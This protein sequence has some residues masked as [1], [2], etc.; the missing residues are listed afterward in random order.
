MK[1]RLLALPLLFLAIT[2]KAEIIDR[3]LV[4]YDTETGL[5]WLDATETRDMNYREVVAEMGVGGRLFGWRHATT[6]ELDQLLYHFG[7][8]P[9]TANCEHGVA[10]CTWGGV[11]DEE[12]L[13]DII[14]ML[15][16]TLRAYFEIS[17]PGRYTYPDGV[18]TSGGIVVHGA[19]PRL[20]D[21]NSSEPSQIAKSL[22]QDGEITSDGIIPGDHADAVETISYFVDSDYR[23]GSTG[24]RLVKCEWVTLTS[25]P[26][27]CVPGLRLVPVLYPIAEGVV[28]W[29][30]GIELPMV[31]IRQEHE[32]K[33]DESIYNDETEFDTGPSLPDAVY[34]WEFESAKGKWSSK[35]FTSKEQAFKFLDEQGFKYQL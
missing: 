16:D 28:Y 18:G 17:E 13:E 26:Y 1:L 33:I 32:Y 2:V 22:L 35:S 11:S 14:T 15:G 27:I 34:F 4:T 29:R 10:F 6:H 19:E 25:N 23:H 21:V 12:L 5:S 20:L 8:V 30:D 9:V 3:G 7:L 24:H 31:L